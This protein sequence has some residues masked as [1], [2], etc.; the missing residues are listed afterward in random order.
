M[1]YIV[2]HTNSSIKVINDSKPLNGSIVS[3][4]NTGD[5][6]SP[7]EHGAAALPCRRN[8]SEKDPYKFYVRNHLRFQPVDATPKSLTIERCHHG[9]TIDQD[10]PQ[11]SL[12][13]HDPVRD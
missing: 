12:P 10:T 8:T 11:K 1:G 2:A 3:I 7:F 13:E 4:D 6:L 5:K 9:F